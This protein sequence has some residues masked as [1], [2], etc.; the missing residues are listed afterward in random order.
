M[1]TN[2]ISNVE[3]SAESTSAAA[4]PKKILSKAGLIVLICTLASSLFFYIIG[5]VIIA[6]ED[7]DYYD[8]YYYGETYYTTA[9]WDYEK[10]MY[11]SYNDIWKVEFYSSNR[12]YAY[13]Y[14]NNASVLNITDS[15]GYSATY[16]LYST[17]TYKNGT[18]YDYCYRVYLSSYKDY[19]VTLSG[20]GAYAYFYVAESI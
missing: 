18:Y 14:V 2:N 1:E 8:D 10:D 6:H 11:L 3:V 17:D 7:D 16:S 5:G 15:D 13:V 20:E 19:T 4:A 12:S 9:S